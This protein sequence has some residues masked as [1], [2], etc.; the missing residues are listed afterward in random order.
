MNFE[1]NNQFE[2]PFS[3]N[4]VDK[5]SCW[6]IFL[7]K[8][9]IMVF[10]YITAFAKSYDIDKH[11]TKCDKL[12]VYPGIKCPK[13]IMTRNLIQKCADFFKNIMKVKDILSTNGCIN[14][15]LFWHDSV[16]IH[17]LW[18]SMHIYNWC[19]FYWGCIGNVFYPSTNSN[20]MTNIDMMKKCLS[21]VIW[22]S[23]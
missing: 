19:G 1:W 16:C 18:V 12:S 22:I 9:F 15:S 23:L 7:S 4:S 8:P 6:I 5:N 2:V 17:V 10:P 13:W 14:F 3:I 11:D 20:T 21:F